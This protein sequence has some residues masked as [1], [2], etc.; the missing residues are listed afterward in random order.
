M[1]PLAEIIGESPAIVALRDRIRQMLRAGAPARRPPPILLEGETGTGKGLLA[2]ALHRASAR[3]GGPFV[4][5]N[6]AALPETLL[7]AELFGYERGAFT[8]ARQSKPGM[9]QLA[10]RGTLLL[11]EVGLLPPALQ[12]KLLA[13]L[14]DRAV[15]R[16]G[17]TRAE[18]V[19]VWILAATNEVLGEA[20]RTGA[21]RE[22][23][24]HRL[25]VLTL[26]L[27]PLRERGNDLFLLAD[28]FLAQA[29]ADYGLPARSL[30]VGARSALRAYAW[31]GNVRELANVIER[32]ALLTEGE[33]IT[34]ALL[35]LPRGGLTREPAPPPA[36]GAGAAPA[37]PD[38]AQS[39]RDMMRQHL[40]STLTRTGWNISQTASILGVS[41]NTVTARI[42]RFGLRP[43]RGAPPDPA[44]SVALPSRAEAAPVPAVAVTARWEPR[45]LCLLLA[46]FGEGIG[47]E[48]SVE[49]ALR[50]IVDKIQ[51]FGG[52]VEGFSPTGVSAVF[53]LEP[54]EEPAALAAHSALVIRNALRRREPPLGPV[55]LG[56]HTAEILVHRAPT[57]TVLDSESSRRA[58]NALDELVAAAPPDTTIVTTAA[59]AA[60]LG[61]RFAL[62][63]AGLEGG[64]Y[65]IDG[66]WHAGRSRG[67][68]A[69]RLAD[70]REEL[71]LLEGRLGLAQRGVGQVIDLVGEAGIGKSRLLLELTGA[72]AARSGRYL[73]GRCSPATENTPL[74]P[75][76]SIL[77]EICGI[78]EMDPPEAVRAGVRAAAHAAGLDAPDV[79]AALT[80]L[81]TS[82]AQPGPEM[83]PR[84]LQR[85]FFAA[86]RDLLIRFSQA[87]PPLLLAVE[88]LHWVDSTS[89]EC[90]EGLVGV[91][92]A[93][94]I[95]LVTT[96]RT[97]YRPP[98]AGRANVTQLTLPPLS[99]EDSRGVVESVLEPEP[100]AVPPEMVTR[101]V[102]RAEGN[103][104]FLEELSR[105]V[106]ER[107]DVPTSAQVPAT[108]EEVIGIR[109][110]RLPPRPRQ[111][112]G[113]AA[114]IG[115]EV[116]A[117]VLR[118]VCWLPED[119]LEEVLVDL[120]GADFLGPSS[121][122]GESGYAFRHALV[123]EVA[124]ARLGA[125]ERRA[126]H[127]KVLDA[128]ERLYSESPG[129]Q[130]EALA[131]HA[132]AAAE[133]SRAIPY[134]YRAGQKAR[135]RSAPAEEIQHLQKGLE[136][137]GALPAG[138][139]RDRQ[140]LEFQTAIGHTLR[141]TRGYGAP[142]V[143]RAYER[144]RELC[145][146]VG[147]SPQLASVLIG[148]WVIHL[149]RAEYERAW[150]IAE[151][152][153]V[154]AQSEEPDFLLEAHVA[155]GMTAI[156]MGELAAA[157]HHL[158][159]TL[160]LYD[161]KSQRQILYGDLGVT[162][163][164]YLAWALWY[165]G[166]PDQALE[167]AREAIAL[168]QVQER[169]GPL[170]V[171]QALGMMASLRQ[172]RGEAREALEAAEQTVA[173]SMDRGFPYWVVQGRITRSW[174]LAVSGQ[175]AGIAP[176][177]Q[178]LE[179]YRATGVK[180]GV[181]RYLALLAD[182]YRRNG[183]A[184]EGLPL[185][186]E[187]AR[188][189]EVTGERYCEAEIQR[190]RGELTILEGGPEAIGA[191]EALL[192]AALDTARRQDAKSW[193][194]RAAIS[195]AR[196]QR[197]QGRPDE[198]RRVLAPVLAW[199]TE[200]WDTAD[201]REASALLSELEGAS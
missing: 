131:H 98:W 9:F 11:D 100:G 61:R 166:Y 199:F 156:F 7:E 176:I 121:S 125:G 22:D 123:H 20:I 106:R 41:R 8:D 97:G 74:Y 119:T 6:C 189:I 50:S 63:R 45:R 179:S 59:A 26:T 196:L 2:R 15:R 35:A 54:S 47:A 67:R 78:V 108:I 84:R 29:C 138:L 128:I 83:E 178:S 70:R 14:E 17:G 167:R 122:R 53:G 165:L 192:A 160:T 150:A 188:L 149:L 163:L 81:L 66:L 80:E 60:L 133:W 134:L 103:P 191:G 21:F 143:Q 25:A 34:A 173:Y 82:D 201:L 195:L 28:R 1:E 144:A 73:E 117:T 72:A 137:L 87:S 12:A 77:R 94:P 104:L 39:S 116:P 99:I 112:L 3:A 48:P 168:A 159:R 180:L 182:M 57:A 124:Y 31:P 91:L 55:V 23:L 18:P 27:P 126:L 10:H 153:L 68:E 65:R 135:A 19:D 197:A 198:A 172:V 37:V 88:D 13:V 86:I 130:V 177:G 101:I 145:Q 36:V 85:R 148:Q 146:R 4:G 158:E 120:Q 42:A 109:I 142:E 24:Y 170:S 115:R 64:G 186:D 155:R 154:L 69:P 5:V 129:E 193:E 136:V 111:I 16:L 30:G 110:D 190:L 162:S 62:A 169:S 140:E 174:A 184:R 40:Q 71:A 79:L 58:W 105:A 185:L 95:L 43:P 161:P 75:V 90:L 141:A 200:G 152:L 102:A 93:A 183:Q 194:L 171:A 44:P 175:E 33:T 113:L 107:H 89:E 56:L 38:A 132:V 147:S 187:A 127:L 118:L 49:P 181:T 157:R 164:A 46:R 32:T 151:Q 92:G 96:Y 139:E 114:V 51:S 76:L 52:K